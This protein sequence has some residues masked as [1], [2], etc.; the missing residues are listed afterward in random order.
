MKSIATFIACLLLVASIAEAAD[1]REF[2]VEGLVMQLNKP[3][4]ILIELSVGSDDGL[5]TGDVLVVSRK[6]KRI[7]EV[8]IAR[9]ESN[10]STANIV[11]VKEG[12]T[13]QAHDRVA[14]KR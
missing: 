13:L 3:G 4:T 5:K 1:K 2:V 12:E 14:N 6:D 7:A 10:R 8:K 11:S 9:C